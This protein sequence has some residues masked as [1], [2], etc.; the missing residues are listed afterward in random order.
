MTL[1]QLIEDLQR[2]REYGS[3][4]IDVQFW[5]PPSGPYNGGDGFEVNHTDVNRDC[6]VIVL[7]QTPSDI[8]VQPV[9]RRT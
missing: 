3:G 6:H 2:I 4:D 5:L 7:S 8:D 9:R 1:D